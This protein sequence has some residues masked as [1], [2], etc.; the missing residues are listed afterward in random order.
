MA[1]AGGKLELKHREVTDDYVEEDY[2]DVL[3]EVPRVLSPHLHETTH[4][5]QRLRSDGEPYLSADQRS[6]VSASA[7][8]PPGSPFVASRQETLFP[9]TEPSN[10]P[11]ET[12][13]PLEPH[14]PA[15]VCPL[16]GQACFQ[17]SSFRQRALSL[18]IEFEHLEAR[19]QA[20]IKGNEEAMQ[21]NSTSLGVLGTDKH[22]SRV[23]RPPAE[24]AVTENRSVNSV[25]SRLVEGDDAPGLFFTRI[26]KADEGYITAEE[27]FAVLKLK[28]YF[29]VT[30][31]EL[32]QLILQT[33]SSVVEDGR[34]TYPQRPGALSE[35]GFRHLLTCRTI[36][37]D[38]S[39]VSL[40]A[41]VYVQA[42]LVE[43]CEDDAIARFMRLSL[44]DIVKNTERRYMWVIGEAVIAFAISLNGI[45]IG[46][47]ADITWEGFDWAELFFLG[48]FSLEVA[49]KLVSQGVRTYFWGP[50][51]SWNLF[52]FAVVVCGI[53]GAMWSL[54]QPS[55]AD[56]VEE[57]SVVRV[58]R[59]ARVVRLVRVLR[60]RVFR[61]LQLMITGI[62]AGLRTLFWAMVLLFVGMFALGVML[63]Q[64]AG[65][66][67]A[68][69]PSD[70]CRVRGTCTDREL[71]TEHVAEN[72]ASL[73]K[74]VPCAMF[75]VFRCLTGDCSSVDGTP[76]SVHLYRM[77]GGYFLVSYWA[78]SI[79]VTFGLFNLVMAIFV[80]SVMEAAQQKRENLQRDQSIR[81]AQALRKFVRKICNT[82]EDDPSETV[83]ENCLDRIR[84]FC[85]IG[86]LEQP[87]QFMPSC[88]NMTITREQFEEVIMRPDISGMLDDM[89]V[90]VFDR[91]DL[92]D[93]LDADGSGEV[94]MVEILGGMMKLRGGADKSD[95]VALLLRVRALQKFVVD[96][97]G[98]LLGQRK[99]AM[100]GANDLPPVRALRSFG[101]CK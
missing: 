2:R 58:L 53:L 100:I 8:T 101:S 61:E 29:R 95:I 37:K 14:D 9:A 68:T 41:V 42:A 75:T 6:N 45:F 12:I 89:D 7:F 88:R 90:N 80:D 25:G 67:V 50:D 59:L 92:F 81:M 94:D 30:L 16:H 86:Q 13:L 46:V 31:E 60:F 96:L 56:D 65:T 73:F 64:T 17:Q 27:L 21:G 83:R 32:K 22:A 11:Q 33:N 55:K 97:G 74:T 43:L 1:N 51:Y 76:L 20:V 85:G 24:R 10:M 28:H 63:R 19:Y 93:I 18:A 82:S 47:S 15:L 4:L 3:Q 99:L 69:M 48:L 87:M 35:S 98:K 36:E 78:V 91:M 40:A 5:E 57:P 49:F 23:S 52:D 66:K 84:N 39:G 26:K 72:N 44:H 79:F 62:I 70:S 34:E 71:S 77:Y 54:A 38:L